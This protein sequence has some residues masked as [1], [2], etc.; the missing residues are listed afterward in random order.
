LIIVELR[1]FKVDKG[2]GDEVEDEDEGENND[3]N[4]NEIYVWFE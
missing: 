2:G 1:Q 3:Q 4:I